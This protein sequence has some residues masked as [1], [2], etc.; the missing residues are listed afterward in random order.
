VTLFK[1][2]FQ[3]GELQPLL[4]EAACEVARLKAKADFSLAF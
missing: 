3:Q 2:V 1:N 4:K